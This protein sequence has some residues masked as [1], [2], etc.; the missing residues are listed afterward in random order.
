LINFSDTAQVKMWDV[1]ADEVELLDS[2]SYSPAGWTAMLD[3]VGL[4]ITKLLQQPDINEEHV[5][6]LFIVISDGYE[7]NSKEYKQ[8]DIAALIDTVNKTKRWSIVYLGANQ[9]LHKVSEQMNLSFHN[10][11]AFDASPEGMKRSII[12]TQFATSSFYGSRLMGNTNTTSFYGN[13]QPP[14][15]ASSKKNKKTKTT[16]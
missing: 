13:S 6:I 12:E 11:S 15:T 16:A 1:P 7:N 2:G 14:T 10:T 4:G 8:K 9:D 5:S 3:A